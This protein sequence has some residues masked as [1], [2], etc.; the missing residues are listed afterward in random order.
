MAFWTDEEKQ[1]IWENRTLTPLELHKKWK[2]KFGDTRSYESIRY[3]QRLYDKND[4]PPEKTGLS[5]AEYVAKLPTTEEKELSAWD[6]LEG[7]LAV[8]SK[9]PR[10]PLMPEKGKHTRVIFLSDLHFG[11]QHDQFGQSF[12]MQVARD[13]LLSIPY[14][15]VGPK[16]DKIIVAFGGDCVEGE[17]IYPNQ[18][19]HI[20]CSAI[21]QSQKFAAASWEM[22]QLLHDRHACPV[23]VFTIP[24]NHGRTKKEASELSNWDNVGYII[25]STL[26]SL[27]DSPIAVHY[28]PNEF[29][30]F[31]SRGKKILLNH[32]GVKH[33]GTPAM[34]TKLAGWREL[35][36]FDMLLHGHWHEFKVGQW[37]GKFVMCNGSLGGVNQYATKLAVGS[38]PMQCYFDLLDGVPPGN[39]HVL[40]W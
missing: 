31:T 32:H 6:W 21:E 2:T 36:D 39:F 13:R 15:L 19:V 5:S 27:S 20:E 34:R 16:P 28:N 35:F 12:N 3:K 30:L 23:E 18:Q 1:F 7:I 11:Q 37:F 17:N 8:A 10:K 40:T 24:G 29:C 22:L 38:P 33:T 25:L 14:K 9:T 4:R 26:A